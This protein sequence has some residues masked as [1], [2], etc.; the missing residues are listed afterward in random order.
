MVDSLHVSTL[1]SVRLSRYAVTTPSVPHRGLISVAAA[2]KIARVRATRR[3]RVDVELP[4]AQPAR[5]SGRSSRGSDEREAESRLRTGGCSTCSRTKTASRRC[6]ASA[7][8]MTLLTSHIDHARAAHAC[9]TVLPGEMDHLRE[10]REHRD[11]DA[12]NA[13]QLK[14]PPRPALSGAAAQR[15]RPSLCRSSGGDGDGVVVRRN[16][17]RPLAGS[18]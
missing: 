3:S 10:I 12:C 9:R 7:P 16:R 5:G 14:H 17:R 1:A 13:E 11:D 4:H 8:T 18:G 6:R 15:S 2:K